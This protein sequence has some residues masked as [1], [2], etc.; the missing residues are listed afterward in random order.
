MPD[1]VTTVLDLTGL[2]LLTLAAFLLAVWA[3]FAIAGAAVLYV[4]WKMA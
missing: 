1:F 2:A 4:S 3:G